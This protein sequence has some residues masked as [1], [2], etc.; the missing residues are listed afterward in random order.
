MSIVINKMKELKTWFYNTFGSI[1]PE[2]LDE[3]FA[4]FASKIRRG[5]QIPLTHVE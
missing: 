3:A 2:I 5:L 1:H 4:G